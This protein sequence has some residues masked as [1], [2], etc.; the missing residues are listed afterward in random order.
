MK[1][2]GIIYAED[3]RGMIRN[4]AA[5]VI[6]LGLAVLPSL[7][8]WFN[9]EASWDP[10]GHTGGLKVAVVN[11][12]KGATLRGTPL[13]VGNEIIASLKQN[14]AIGWVFT[15]E[16]QALRGVTRGKYYASITI[17]E[18]FSAR[19]AT[20]LSDNPQK[21]VLVYTVNEKINAIAPKI[22]AQGASGIL[23][24]VDQQFNKTA[25][26]VIFRIFNELG[27]G[28]E[29]NLPDILQI[30]NAVFKLEAFI[31]ELN[32]AV[33]VMDRDT[34]AVNELIRKV[35]TD[36][37]IVAELAQEGA[38][39]SSRMG[40]FLDRSSAVLDEAEPAIKLHLGL[41]RQTADA[42]ASLTDILL[43]ESP[44]PAQ[45]RATL[46]RLSQ[47]LT[48]ASDTT[49]MLLSLFERV[50]Q[51][52]GGGLLLPVTE[53]LQQI[54]NRIAQQQ[55]LVTQIVDAIDQ[56]AQPA[57]EL[58]NRLNQLARESSSAVGS[59]LDRYDDETAPR[60]RQA[61][62]RVQQT[63]AKTQTLLSDANESIPDVERI[64]AHAGKVLEAGEQKVAGLKQA[65]PEAEDKVR[66]LAD[67]IRELEKAGS[68]EELIDLLKNNNVLLSDFFAN[69]V[70]LE[71]NVLFP[72]PNYGS[73]MSPFFTTLSLWVGAL[74]LVSL[75]SVEIHDPGHQFRG[76]QIYFGRYLSFL[77]IALLQSLFVTLGDIWLLKTYVVDKPWFI[78]FGLLLSTV[79]ML[80]VYTLVSV[81]GN[82]GKAMAIVLLVL[83]LAGSGGTFPIEVTPAF[84]QAI[85]PFLPFTYAISMMREAVGG[86]VWDTV[87]RDLLA[88]AAFAAA[89][90]VIGLALKNAINRLSARFVQKARE[91]NLIH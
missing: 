10:Y 80:I 29:E 21:A 40:Q 71:E 5:L 18:D 30:R 64:V 61:F 43:N 53:K 11:K 88:I 87:R 34:R 76:Y 1:K 4:W 8:A 45:T 83:Q 24:E 17:Q 2:I 7:Y 16:E 35:Q 47:R 69:P 55:A 12:D 32:H 67:R 68:L 79:F 41:L 73:A 28:L 72:I 39:F 25:S 52:A 60:I 91:S 14:H 82:V 62:D 15:D 63:V 70:I 51:L 26:D 31:P 90:L 57:S 19:I 56:G 66:K 86:I 59:M 36:L 3:I 84:F 89:A 54:D 77:T 74:L 49:G 37:P 20:V 85:H 27:I 48:A 50:N 22:T 78:V 81:F 58:V 42:T 65:L 6:I 9:I 46:A 38:D 33:D 13:N 23:H 44:D 75:L